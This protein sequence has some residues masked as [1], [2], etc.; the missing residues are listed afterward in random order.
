M[1]NESSRLSARDWARAALK[2]IAD[3]G[4]AAVA[5]EPLART[6]GV[7][8]G[9]FYAH[10]RNRDELITAA[11]E[12][13]GRSHGT[14]GLTEF[15]AITDPAERL[16]ELLTT[17]VRAVQPLAPSVH[18]SLLGDRNDARVRNAVHQVNQARL[19]L[20]ARTYRELGLPPSRAES[21]AR[22]A[23]AAILGLSQLAQT[24]PDAP[25]SAVLAEEAA[26]LFLTLG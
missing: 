12:E 15:A 2:A 26:A 10:Y 14:E 1:V 17:V 24:D 13:W 9:S 11:L 3:G 16:R 6:L 19:E 21:R 5:V 18:L 23:Y 7:T 8:K 20:L 4:L 22:V 25:R